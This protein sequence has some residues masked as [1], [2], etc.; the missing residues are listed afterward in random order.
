MAAKAATFALRIV[1]QVWTSTQ[2]SFLFF[3][4]FLLKQGKKVCTKQRSNFISALACIYR[5]FLR[6][7][8]NGYQT[9]KSYI[10]ELLTAVDRCKNKQHI[11]R[12]DHTCY[13]ALGRMDLQI[14]RL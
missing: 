7:D 1:E 3:I 13:W 5:Y 12:S 9:K 6:A 10:G 14:R 8:Q 4:Y 2:F 11:E